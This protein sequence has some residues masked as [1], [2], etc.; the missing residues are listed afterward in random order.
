[1]PRLALIDGLSRNIFD[2]SHLTALRLAVCLRL[3]PQCRRDDG[4]LIIPLYK[5]EPAMVANLV[6]STLAAGG[7]LKATDPFSHRIVYSAAM[8]GI[9][10]LWK[11]GATLLEPCRETLRWLQSQDPQLDFEWE[12]QFIAM[13]IDLGRGNDMAQDV[14]TKQRTALAELEDKMTRCVLCEGSFKWEDL[15][16]AECS[17]GHRYRKLFIP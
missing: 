13:A 10:G 14:M 7:V 8:V 6:M 9:V 3:F 15:T 16:I 5:D 11:F 1:M 2:P 12:Q 4:A 17:G